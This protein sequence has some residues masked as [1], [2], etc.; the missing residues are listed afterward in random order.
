MPRGTVCPYEIRAESGNSTQRFFEC[1]GTWGAGTTVPCGQSC[2]APLANVIELPTECAART[3]VS[4]AEASETV[5]ARPTNQQRLD[6]IFMGVLSECGGPPYGNPL[7]LDVSDGCPTRLSTGE[8]LDTPRAD[9]LRSRLDAV[10]WDCAL[11]LTC[12]AFAI[13]LG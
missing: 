1:Q 13:V 12:S 7:Q 2:G 3:M 4:C 10:R 8:P 11:G 5:F 6:E 9:C